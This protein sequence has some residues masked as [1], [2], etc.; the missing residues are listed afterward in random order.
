MTYFFLNTWTTLLIADL[1]SALEPPE[2]HHLCGRAWSRPCTSATNPWRVGKTWSSCACA[3]EHWSGIWGFCCG[4]R[5]QKGWTSLWWSTWLQAGSDLCAWGQKSKLFFKIAAHFTSPQAMNEMTH[6][7]TSLPILNLTCL[8]YYSHPCGHEVSISKHKSRQNGIT[9]P[10]I[11]A[12]SF[13]SY[14]HLFHLASDFVKAA[15]WDIVNI[16]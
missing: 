16:Q 14:H 2:P 13:N 6:L 10:H 8:F 5:S 15:F 12:S 11:P 1:Y 7:S 3:R 9:N 4:P